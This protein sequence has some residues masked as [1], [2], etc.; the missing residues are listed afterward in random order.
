MIVGVGIDLIE[1]ERIQKAAERP[2][3]L[4]RVYTRQEVEY[5][6]GRTR[7]LAGMFAVK[8]AVSKA[9]GTGISGFGLTD[10]EVFHDLKGRPFVRLREGAER[11]AAAIGAVNIQ[12][13]VSDLEKLAGAMAV[14]ED[15]NAGKEAGEKCSTDGF[16]ST[17]TA[18]RAKS[19]SRTKT[20]R[21]TRAD[22]GF[23]M[24]E[25]SA[26]LEEEMELCRILGEEAPESGEPPVIS[27]RSRLTPGEMKILRHVVAG[28][29][30]G[31]E[32]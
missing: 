1:I 10:I 18:G 21:R 17:G 14:A 32:E 12:V 9:L 31:E 30:A 3:F 6:A 27:L 13:S 7:I 2:S 29:L 23:Y 24:D 19:G 11:R 8:E 5:A 28:Q 4:A 16:D 22:S 20:D 26:N 15:S 25:L